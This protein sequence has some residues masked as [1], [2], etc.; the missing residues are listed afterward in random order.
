MNNLKRDLKNLARASSYFEAFM[1]FCL[2]KLD[3]NPSSISEDK[4]EDIMSYLK[5][6]KSLGGKANLEEIKN[7]IKG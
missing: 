2:V 1:L 3:I 5:Y 6:V 4:K 7:I